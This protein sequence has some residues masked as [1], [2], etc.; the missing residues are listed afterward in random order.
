MEDIEKGSPKSSSPNNHPN[1]D[2][3]INMYPNQNVD[4]DDA[5]KMGLQVEGQR[6]SIEK[7]DPCQRHRVIEF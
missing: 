6:Y 2:A 1:N 3:S 5:L 4:V 7:H